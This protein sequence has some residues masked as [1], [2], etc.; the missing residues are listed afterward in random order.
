MDLWGAITEA[1]LNQVYIYIG[2]DYKGPQLYINKWSKICK[3]H[4]YEG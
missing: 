2:K 3:S 4:K 1:G